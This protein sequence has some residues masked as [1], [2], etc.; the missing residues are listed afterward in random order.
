MNKTTRAG[1]SGKG[2]YAALSLSVAMVGAAC[3][4]A[5]SETGRTA[6]P[7]AESSITQQTT[8]GTTVSAAATLP[9]AAA[10]TTAASVTVTT[11]EAEEAAAI[12]RRTTTVT[13]PR[14][15]RIFTETETA[16]TTAPAAQPA[17]PVEGTV[18]Q[19]FSRGELVRSGTTGIW[20]THNGTD[21][22][23]AVGTDVYA[24]LDG[25]VIAVERDALWGVTVTLL[26]ESG[27]VTRYCGLNENLNVQAGDVIP[28]GTVIGAVGDTNEAESAMEPHLHFDVLINDRFAD[29]EEFL[30][31]GLPQQETTEST[32]E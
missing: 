12:L 24:V 22:A 15:E 8:S 28:R 25:T 9:P 21:F 10:S 30:A 29:P 16:L 4:Y 23:A 6:P 20:Q 32:A 26:H 17:A 14:S 19:P 1:M 31:G 7:R 18:I 27:A 13:T 2:F 3:W 5:Y 11:A